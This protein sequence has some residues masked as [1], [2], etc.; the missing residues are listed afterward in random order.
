MRRTLPVREGVTLPAL[1]QSIWT[2]QIL[3]ENNNNG[4]PFWRCSSPREF[5]NITS[6]GHT[7]S[8]TRGC[9]S[10]S[11]REWG[12]DSQLCRS[13]LEPNQTSSG[14]WGY[15][16]SELALINFV[17]QLV[18]IWIANYL[19][20]GQCGLNNLVSPGSVLLQRCWMCTEVPRSFKNSHPPRTPRGP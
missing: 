18:L 4:K 17:R 3:Y 2:H 16:V 1:S 8:R 19:C 5:S 9:A 7:R 15:L 13:L 14:G 20:H 12:S 11:A 6:W 10:H